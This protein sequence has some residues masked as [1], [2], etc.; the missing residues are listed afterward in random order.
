MTRRGGDVPS[1][2]GMTA[3]PL[4]ISGGNLRDLQY[5]RAD[6]RRIWTSGPLPEIRDEQIYSVPRRDPYI[7]PTMLS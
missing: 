5:S 3:S 7:S 2:D 1:D 6:D 4:R